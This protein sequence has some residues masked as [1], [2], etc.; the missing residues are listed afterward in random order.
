MRSY[1]TSLVLTFVSFY[2]Y[3]QIAA[4]PGL[5]DARNASL[6][7]SRISLSG[8]WLWKD[9]VLAE[10]NDSVDWQSTEFPAV[11]NKV[12]SNKSGIG[13]ATYKLQVILP[14]GAPES[15][16]MQL[17]QMYSG[18]KVWIN[19][20]AVGSNGTPGTSRETTTP[21]WLPQVVSFKHTSDTINIHLQIANF[22]HD[23]GG[24]K[25]PIYIG[26]EKELRNFHAYTQ[27]SKMAEAGVLLVLFIAFMIVFLKNPSK[28]VI[29]YFA[30][31]SLTWAIRS[32]FSNDYLAIVFFPD[33]DWTWMVRIEYLSLY[34]TMIWAILFLSR[35]F[36]NEGNQIIKYLL[37][38]LNVGYLVFTLFTDPTSF[39][40]WLM[41]YLVTSAVLLVYGAAIAMIALV[42]ERKGAAYIT[43]S[44]M[45]GLA[46]FSYDIFTYE[47]WFAYNSFLFSAAY[48]AL[49]LL[50]GGA[51]LLHLDII[52]SSPTGTTTLTYKDLYGDEN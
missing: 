1:F 8:T 31:L 20:V 34:L 3:A 10:P 37:V 6:N 2:S 40:K 26:E 33:F 51:L 12:R 43:T 49:F 14:S 28:R 21:Q 4:T 47:G 22:H 42:N 18:Y 41:V 19:G 45:L 38:I 25:D 36:K 24:C 44:V 35:L 11:W 17:P 13:V 46:I 9:G 5:L 16:A 29:V 39:T 30:L 7:D 23:T 52:K 15:M 50:M 32:V 27:Y 48:V